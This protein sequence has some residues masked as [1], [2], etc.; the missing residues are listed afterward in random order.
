MA[1]LNRF[2]FC[3]LDPEGKV[4]KDLHN[5]NPAFLKYKFSFNDIDSGEKNI[6]LN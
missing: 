3:L 5:E 1:L 4:V 6:I 2:C